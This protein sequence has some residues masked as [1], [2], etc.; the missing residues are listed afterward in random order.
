MLLLLQSLMEENIHYIE[1]GLIM[2][3]LLVKFFGKEQAF[4]KSF[5]EKSIT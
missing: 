1:E 2:R 3:L 5:L 4:L